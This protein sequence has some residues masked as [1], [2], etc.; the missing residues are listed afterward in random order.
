MGHY[1]VRLVTPKGTVMTLEQLRQQV[2]LLP[3][4]DR[5]SLI[6]E[7]IESLESGETGE[8]ISQSWLDEITRRS[9]A[10]H[11]GEMECDDW[12]TSLGRVRERLVGKSS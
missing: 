10:L 8:E 2:L 1:N 3:V 6:R 11:R 4:Q 5:A 7:L 9:E 12:R